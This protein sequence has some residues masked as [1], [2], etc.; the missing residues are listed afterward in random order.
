MGGSACA[1][2]SN[3]LAQM[4]KQQSVDRTH[5]FE[6]MQSGPGAA[7]LRGDNRQMSAADRQLLQNMDKQQ[8]G[9]NS[10]QYSDMRHELGNMGQQSV[11]RSH[12]AASANPEWSNDFNAKFATPPP[13][14]QWASEFNPQAQAGPSF[15][16]PSQISQPVGPRM[17]FMPSQ[18]GM[19]VGM[20]RPMQSM[21]PQAQQSRVTELDSHRWEEQFKN[22]ESQSATATPQPQEEISQTT[23]DSTTQE[24]TQNE[25]VSVEELLDEKE[26]G[27]EDGYDPAWFEGDESRYPPGWDDVWSR[28]KDKVG[29][30]MAEPGRSR[31][32]DFTSDFDFY[33]GSNPQYGDYQFAEKNQYENEQDPFALGVALMDQGAKLSLAVLCFEA[34]LKRDANHIEAWS[35]LGA[36]QAQNECEEAAI[37]AL[38]QCVKLDPRNEGAL[39]NLAVSYTNEGYENAAYATME[40]WLATKYP[41]LVTQAAQDN[42]YLGR[43]ELHKKVTDL[44]IKAAQL[45][46]DIANMDVDVQA[47]LGVLFYGNEEYDKAVDCFRAAINVRPNDPLLWNRLGATLANSSRPEQAIEA[48]YKALELRPSFVRARYNVGVSCINIGCYREAVEH[49]LSALSLHDTGATE[50]GT[51]SKNLYE[52]LRRVFLAMDRQDLIKKV[53]PGMNLNDF[54]QEFSF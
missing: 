12:A 36:A 53:G 15:A 1:A 14:S 16:G 28:I 11:P 44:F 42:P 51:D 22:I 18:M 23:A 46:P 5:Q 37:R 24:T 3:P 40:R 32:G 48:Y 38:E 7:S 33:A 27:I 4:A 8:M 9:P 17:S 21:Q 52:T 34:A 50:T 47:G 54:R 10:F 39:M 20:M 19:G 2:G 43:L 45:S 26:I 6:Q 13:Q 49:L 30:E 41:D 35:R 29:D 25:E 31:A